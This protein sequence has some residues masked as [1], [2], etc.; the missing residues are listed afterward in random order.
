MHNATLVKINDLMKELIRYNEELHKKHKQIKGILVISV[1]N[2][3]WL[4]CGSGFRDQTNSDPDSGQTLP[5]LK[6]KF[7]HENLTFCREKIKT[8]TCTLAYVRTK[9]LL[10]GGNQ[11]YS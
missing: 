4:Q 6:V 3:H 2:Q 7:L 8:H 11:V 9:S 1:E 10:K 5:S